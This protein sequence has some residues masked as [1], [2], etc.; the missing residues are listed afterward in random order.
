[1][2][3]R[4]RALCTLDHKEPDRVCIDFGATLATGISAV[5]YD[6]AKK[7]LGYD[8]ITTVDD[9]IAQNAMIEPEMLEEM[10]GDFVNIRRYAPALGI[11]VA[12]FKP[13]FLT[14]GTPAL[15]P[16]LYN[17]R[18]NENGDLELFGLSHSIDYIHPYKKGEADDAYCAKVIS[19][20]PKGFDAYCRVFHPMKHVETVAELSE[21]VFPE[22]TNP[23]Y[24][25]Y[26]SEARRLRETTDKAV[27]AIFLGNVFEMGQLYW[28]YEQFFVHMGVNPELVINYMERRTECYL[29]DLKKLLDGAGQYIDVI[30]FNDDL[31]TQQSLLISK[32]MYREF[33]KPYHKRMFMFVRENYPHIKVYFHTCGA[34]YDLIPDLIDCGVQILNPIQVSAK[35]MDPRTIKREFGHDLTLWGGGIDTQNVLGRATPDEIRAKVKE[36]LDIFA[37]GGGYVFSQVHHVGGNVPPENLIACFKTAR[38]YRM[39]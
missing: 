30:Q 16:A 2:T 29:R 17:P 21:Y 18:K 34:I 25:F 23:E 35:G 7:Q 36:M 15:Q 38:E 11:P 32:A 22:M 24:D 26:M 27:T 28:G 33:I 4:E 10:G 14:N 6:A 31:G 3:S 20:C 37:P 5:V 13:S 8:T 12:D 1:M 9:I 39:K 19:R